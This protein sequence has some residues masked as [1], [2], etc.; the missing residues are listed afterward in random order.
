MHEYSKLETTIANI[1]YVGMILLGTVTIAYA[2]E[3]SVWRVAG[4]CTYLIY[5]IVGAFWIMIFVCPYCHYYA[6]KGCPC[7]Y[8]MISAIIVRKGDKDCFAQKFKRHIPVIIPLW[9]I[10]MVCGGLE[11]HSSFSWLLLGLVLAFIIESWIILPI[12]SRTHGCIECP[13]KEQCP[14]MEKKPKALKLSDDKQRK[15]CLT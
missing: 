6:T 15:K 7:G 13:Q 14:W 9:I 8:G 5:G 4:A 1:P 2:S 12:V 10:P 3:F 11:L